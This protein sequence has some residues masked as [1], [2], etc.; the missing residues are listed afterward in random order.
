MKTLTTLSSI[1]LIALLT[2]CGNGKTN[3]GGEPAAENSEEV[4]AEFA[5]IPKIAVQTTFT[6]AE[7]NRVVN[8]LNGKEV[9]LT[10]Y[11]YAYPLG[12]GAEIEFQPN[13]SEMLDGIDNSVD[14]CAIRIKFKNE[15]EPRKMHIGDL[16]AVKGILE[17][18]YSVSE[19]WGNT[20][21]ISLSEA[22]YVEK[23]TEKGGT[24][25]SFDDL[26]LSK[27]IFCGDLFTLMDEHYSSLT[28]KKIK[29]QGHY[30]ST[31]TS[32][33]TGG[34]ILEIRVDLGSYDEKVG[35]AMKAEPDEA[36]LNST[37]EAGKDALIEGTFSGIVFG[38]PRIS[39]GL[40]K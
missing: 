26:D 30:L 33:S 15:T 11:P 20:T 36:K 4:N 1:V 5:D 37:R 32:K 19:N 13:S 14:K 7:L 27:Q 10:G 16:F 2:A 17:I 22:E 35:C 29:V 39:G 25:K 21:T 8:F 28:K 31:T 9:T 34:E 12:K 23:A 38:S 18:S 40:V 6:T 3:E 24:L